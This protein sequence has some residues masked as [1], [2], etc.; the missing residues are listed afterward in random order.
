ML[1]GGLIHWYVYKSCSVFFIHLQLVNTKG[2][3]QCINMYQT[4]I[5]FACHSDGAA[6]ASYLT[7]RPME[8]L[9]TF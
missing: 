2:W 3:G 9:N 6:L 4:L 5:N 1:G 7:S 8:I